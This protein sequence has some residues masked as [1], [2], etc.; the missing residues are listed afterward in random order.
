MSDVQDQANPK[1]LVVVSNRLSV[2]WQRS[3]TGQWEVHSSTSGLVT[4]L[5]PLLGKRKGMWIGWPGVLEETNVDELLKVASQAR[6]YILRP[7][8]L[9]W[10]KS[11]STMSVFPTISNGRFSMTYS[12]IATF[13]RRIGMHTGR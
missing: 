12:Q 13:T 6:G 2:T 11:T 5:V 8:L 7:V 3:G 4:A 9:T 1:A 10:K